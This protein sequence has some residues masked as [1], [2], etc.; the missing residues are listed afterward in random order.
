MPH[1]RM[2]QGALA[3]EVNQLRRKVAIPMSRVFQV[4]G[5]HFASVAYSWDAKVNDLQRKG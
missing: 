5:F 2:M 1:E 4:I 3:D